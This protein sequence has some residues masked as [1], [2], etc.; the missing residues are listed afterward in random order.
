ML[1]VH[2]LKVLS[3]LILMSALIGAA[4]IV[5]AQSIIKI[6][7]SSTVYPITKAVAKNFQVAKKDVVKV[8]VNISSSGDGFNKFCRGE[9]DIVNASRPILENEMAECKN[10]RVKFVEIPVAFDAIT[11]AVNPDNNW[12]TTVTVAQLKK[13]WEPIAQGRITKWNQINPAW[14]NED[15]KLFGADSAS[16]TFDY[17]T[18]AIVGKSKLSRGDYVESEDD[19]VLVEGVANNKNGL[20]F[21]GFHYYIENQD[22]VKAVAIDSGNG[23][24]LPSVETVENGS[25]QPLSRP[26]FIYVSIKAAEKPEVREFVEFY[27]KNA[28]LQVKKAKSFPLPPSAYRTMLEHF[29]NKRSGTVFN[30]RPAIGLTIDDLIR[31]EGRTEF[32]HY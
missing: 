31:R 1:Q 7:G 14:P 21:F 4:D 23:G 15:F 12:S 17:F 13:I 3:M 18:K 6:D 20:G 11:V 2:T 27:M 10:S 16:G 26:I 29:N 9:I 5:S 28:L 19:N 8:M 30:G 24:V 22:K 32:E 25:Y